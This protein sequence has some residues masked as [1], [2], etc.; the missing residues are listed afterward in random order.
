MEIRQAVEADIP[1]IGRLLLRVCEV[2]RRG[3]PDL[4]R[5]N[6]RKYDD[7]QLRQI[8]ADPDAPVLVAVEDG[9]L[10]GYSFCVVQRHLNEGSLNDFTTLY[11]DDLCIDENCRG[12]HVGRALYDATLALA[13]GLDCHSLTLNVWCCNP[14][15]MAFYQRMGLTPQKIGMEQLLD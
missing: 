13:R 3:R 5:Q 11:L 8:L 10:L 15:A 1:E 2:H 9:R 4:F 6:G 7:E 12:R 14:S